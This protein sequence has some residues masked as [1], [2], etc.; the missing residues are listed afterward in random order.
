[1][2]IFFPWKPVVMIWLLLSTM[3]LAGYIASALM[4]GRNP[5]A[6]YSLQRPVHSAH[7]RSAHKPA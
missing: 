1:M 5:F 6:P 2:L 4:E 3:I 7:H